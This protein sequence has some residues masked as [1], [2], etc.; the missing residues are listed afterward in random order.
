MP[1]LLSWRDI[2]GSLYD[3]RV[4]VE[5]LYF[6]CVLCQVVTDVVYVFLPLLVVFYLLSIDL[7]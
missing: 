2:S 7:K 5:L 1:S 6:I 3:T 4:E